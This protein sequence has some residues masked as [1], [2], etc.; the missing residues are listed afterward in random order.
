MDPVIGGALITGG[1]TLLGGLGSNRA[2]ARAATRIN[3][4]QMAFQERMSSTAYQRAT[5]DMK[6]AGIN[7]MLAYMQGGASTPSGAGSVPHME[8][9]VGQAAQAGVS[10]AME[11]RRLRK[12]I[13]AVDSQ[14]KL[15][16]AAAETQ[17]AQEKLNLQNAA[18]A[19]AQEQKAEMEAKA[20][21]ATLPAIKERS[22]R[23]AM[24]EKINQK[25]IDVDAG[26]NRVGKIGP[27][28][29]GAVGGALGGMFRS[30]AKQGKLRRNEAIVNTK[31][32]EIRMERD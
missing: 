30:S 14:N 27:L 7:P 8:N 2:N 3:R 6:A 4:E 19:R 22:Q 1:A 9:A 29:G 13:D 32:G 21:K 16:A 10:T 12:E 28:L 23:E 17:R 5:A 25:L 31:T 18:T 26:L 24:E 15:N 20:L 11:A